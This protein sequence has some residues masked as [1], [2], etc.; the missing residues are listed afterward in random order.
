MCAWIG[1]RRI[2]HGG[3]D[4]LVDGGTLLVGV[5]AHGDVVR[6]I[7]EMHAR[8]RHAELVLGLRIQRDAV[9]FL[10]HV[11]ADQPH[12]GHTRIGFHRAGE[13]ASPRAGVQERRHEGH[14][15]RQRLHLVAADET[16]FGVVLRFVA[17]DAGHGG[18]AIHVHR[19]LE[20]RVHAAGHVPH[21][22]AA[23]LPGRV[24]KA[25]RE[26]GRGAIEQ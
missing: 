9:G 6:M 19:L 13:G 23:D 11:L 8:H 7:V 16:A 22:V 26:H 10:R 25:V 3:A 1:R 21:I 20:R 15:D 12:A 14:A 24:G 18:A 4:G 2:G 5:I 17:D